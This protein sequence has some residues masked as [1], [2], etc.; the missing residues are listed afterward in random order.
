MKTI[1]TLFFALFLICSL[2]IAQDTMYVYKSGSVVSKRA[3]A[4]IDSVIFY[5]PA[6][7]KV[8]DVD[9]NV[10]NTVIIGTQTWMKENLKVTHYNDGSTAI[11]LVT[12][13]TTWLNYAA[14]AYSNYNNTINADT[15]NT[16]GRLYNWYM[17][18][19]GNLCPTGWHVP[20]DAEWTTLTTYLGGESVAGG[21]LKETG[22]T[23]WKSSNT[24]ASNITNF[25]ALPGGYR[26][27]D[28][29]FVSIGG[30]GFWWSSSESNSNIALSRFMA[31]DGSSVYKNNVNKNTGYSVRCLKN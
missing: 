31:Y 24:G 10:Y 18:N 23:H 8:T 29:T 26:S 14:P 7:N 20:S 16:Y 25:T 9:G 11:P 21:K 22:L 15:I 2:A 12:N 27:S 5:S 3:T 4:A 30:Y 19:T 28:G 13:N 17:V 1:I 6:K